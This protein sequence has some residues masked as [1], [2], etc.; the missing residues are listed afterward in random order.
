MA[1]H[2]QFNVN[3]GDVL[4]NFV[5]HA[6]KFLDIQLFHLLRQTSNQWHLRSD[7]TGIVI[8]NKAYYLQI[9]DDLVPDVRTTYVYMLDLSKQ[10]SQQVNIPCQLVAVIKDN[11]HQQNKQLFLF[12]VWSISH[13]W[14]LEVHFT[15]R[16]SYSST[17]LRVWMYVTNSSAASDGVFIKMTTFTF[18]CNASSV[19][20]S[21]KYLKPSTVYFQAVTL[22]NMGG[23]WRIG[24]PD[25]RTDR[26]TDA[27][28]GSISYVL[29]WN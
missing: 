18:Q 23:W 22:F 19:H 29:A 28:P 4:L 21:D 9:K 10:N 6:Q 2:C 26:Q 17:Q 14:L 24:W 5:H 3:L 16:D 25:G 27:G 15:K 12:V 13:L 1:A 20:I 8:T 7:S 11:N